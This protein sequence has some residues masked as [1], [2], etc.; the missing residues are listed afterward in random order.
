MAVPG[1]EGVAVGVVLAVNPGGGGGRVEVAVPLVTVAAGLAKS[2]EMYNNY[3][4][5]CNSTL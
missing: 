5:L 3:I 4:V 2:S 1:I